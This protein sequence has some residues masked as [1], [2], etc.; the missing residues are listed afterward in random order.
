MPHP[1][2]YVTTGALLQC[3][4]G[5]VPMP[6]TTTP[7]TS[8]IAGLLAGNALDRAPLLN[9]PSFVI[10]QKLT[11]MG[12]GT[13]VP[14]TPQPLQ[15][16]NT[17]PAKV[18]GAATL[19]FR[20]CL[21]C[22][23]G[24]GKIEFL[25]SGQLPVP[26][27]L[28]QQIK[29]TK[30]E[31]DEAL[32]QAEKEKN[33]V[34]EA[35]LGESLIPIW[36]SGRDLI[37]A[38]QTGDKL[39]VVLNAG[40]LVWDAASVVAGALSFGTATAG[41]MAGKAGVK[42]AL[43]A[44]GHVALGLARKKMAALAAKG[45][46]LKSGLRGIRAFA[47]KIPR[48][49]VTACFPAGTPVA[50]EGGYQNIED[51]QVGDLVWAWQEE[52][53]DLALQPVVQTLQRTADA[54][55]ELRVGADTVRAT[56]E[57]PFWANGAWTAAGELVAGD[58]LLRS[59]GQ[60][61]PVG[62]VVHHTEQSVPVYNLEVAPWHTYL[63]SWWMFVVHNATVCLSELKR[64]LLARRYLREVENLTKLKVHPKQ[65]AE[66]KKAVKSKKYT[67]LSVE[68]TEKSRKEFNKIKNS[69][70]EEWEKETGQKW[71]RYDH[72]VL[73]KKGKPYIKKGDKY[74]A[75]HLIENTHGGEH[76]WWNIHPA[77]NPDIHQ[78][79]IHGKDG[80]SRFL[81]GD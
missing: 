49:C 72:D 39:G 21:H 63:V 11:Q 71:P 24:Q 64:L 15:W 46:A 65:M 33:S 73:S 17:Y 51:V 57:H 37:H 4:Q 53:G 6:F 18:G 77:K 70:V 7:R 13:P 9:I 20:S 75:H 56:P 60:T 81:F 48:V 50:V 14:C 23:L 76:E 40:F 30:Q 2:E 10:C 69:L 12:G 66:L 36:G 19:L 3:S 79:G 32:D 25:T 58:Q 43:K 80:L 54:L 44:G 61:M 59:D 62:A 26:P 28:S 5:T 8:K 29:E 67:K 38:A 52:T 31:A 1:L 41:M 74:D 34:G 35:S 55:V 47:A 42:A 16:E 68:E 27:A 22:P 78:G 45:A